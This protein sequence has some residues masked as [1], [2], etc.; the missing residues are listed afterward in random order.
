MINSSRIP[1]IQSLIYSYFRNSA[2]FCLWI[3]QRRTNAI[4]RTMPANPATPNMIQIMGNSGDSAADTGGTVVVEV[5]GFVRTVEVTNRGVAR[6]VDSDL[7]CWVMVASEVSVG[8]VV[9]APAP[10]RVTAKCENP[11]VVAP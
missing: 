9:G 7:I 10:F 5:T 2:G 1:Q 6:V 11:D 3:H 4:I 8:V